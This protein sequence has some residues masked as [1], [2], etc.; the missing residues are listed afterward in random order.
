L[1]AYAEEGSQWQWSDN[2]IAQMQRMANDL[3]KRQDGFVLTSR[4][5]TV[6][7]KVSATYTVEL[8]YYLDRFA[9]L[10]RSTVPEL[11][12]P[13]SDIRPRVVIYANKHD[14]DIRASR[15]TGGH[16]QWRWRGGELAEMG[17]YTYVEE[18]DDVTFAHSNPTLQTIQ[19]EAIH[20]LLQQSLGAVNTPSWF[21]EGFAMYFGAWDVQQS[22]DENRKRLMIEIGRG[23]IGL[24]VRRDGSYPSIE[25]LMKLQ[26]VGTTWRDKGGISTYLNY[27]A[28]LSFMDCL[29]N[30]EQAKTYFA[31]LLEQLRHDRARLF[32]D[33]QLP[34]LQQ[35]W[36]IRLDECIATAEQA[37]KERKESAAGE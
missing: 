29:L 35:R 17:F 5:W 22:V 7:T 20:C 36:H 10:M 2:D 23:P 37:A 27:Q 13:V 8:A 11:A 1:R 21:H 28:A 32:D 19:H 15:D 9:D 14:Y 6:E 31:N 25:A 18:E 30:E 26:H 34:A 12:K 24:K 33:D 4:C 3:R 16:A